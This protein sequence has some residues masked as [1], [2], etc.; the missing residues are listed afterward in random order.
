MQKIVIL[1]FKL[2]YY[3]KLSSLVKTKNSTSDWPLYDCFPSTVD[4]ITDLVN[5]NV[6]F[7]WS[8]RI[9]RVQRRDTN[10]IFRRGGGLCGLVLILFFEMIKNYTCIVGW[11]WLDM[12]GKKLTLEFRFVVRFK[13]FVFLHNVLI[14]KLN[15]IELRNVMPQSDP[16]SPIL[17]NEV[18][19]IF[20][21]ISNWNLAVVII[22]FF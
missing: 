18:H 8:D 10:L 11:Q 22:D 9:D 7:G 3:W 2:F 4:R 20:I 15:S 6:L 19:E 5:W 21:L 16:N 17:T 14:Q 12:Y 13:S 1:L